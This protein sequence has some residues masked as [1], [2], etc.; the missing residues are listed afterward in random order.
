MYSY[1]KLITVF[2]RSICRY[3]SVHCCKEIFHHKR[4]QVPFC[5]G[6]I[7][8]FTVEVYISLLL[9]N[10]DQKQNSSLLLRLCRM[11]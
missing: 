2:Q 5:V 3:C 4:E 8:F 7:R 11:F 10:S 9:K 6:V 1:Q